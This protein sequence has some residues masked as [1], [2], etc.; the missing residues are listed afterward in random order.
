MPQYRLTVTSQTIRSAVSS[1]VVVP[2]SHSPNRAIASLIICTLKKGTEDGFQSS[3]HTAYSKDYEPRFGRDMLKHQG[4][5]IMSFRSAWAT[6]QDAPY[7]KYKTIHTHSISAI[8]SHSGTSHSRATSRSG[9]Q[10]EFNISMFFKKEE[11]KKVR[12]GEK[13]MFNQMY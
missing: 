10:E 11:C 6:E 1:T 5:R 12:R 9:I 8:A 4:R 13:G 7:L 3:Q 2:H